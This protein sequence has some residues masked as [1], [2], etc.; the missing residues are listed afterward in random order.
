MC[1]EKSFNKYIN[2]LIY[3]NFAYSLD[4]LNIDIKIN[5]LTNNDIKIK[6]NRSINKDSF[7]C[8]FTMGEFL[9]ILSNIKIS[10]PK[11]IKQEEVIEEIEVIEEPTTEVEE[12][13]LISQ[14]EYDF[15]IRKSH[16]IANILETTNIQN[17]IYEKVVELYNSIEKAT[18]K[19]KEKIVLQIKELLK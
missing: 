4:N 3:K 11:E 2:D 15:I 5:D 14:E 8:A 19:D 12:E 13:R 6:I 16:T 17:D 7:D 9:N 1:D 18:K 10:Q